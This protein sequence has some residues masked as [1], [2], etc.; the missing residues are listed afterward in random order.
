MRVYVVQYHD[1]YGH[2]D[3]RKVSSS[4]AGA[5]DYIIGAHPDA[6]VVQIEWNSARTY[7]TMRARYPGMRGGVEIFFYSIEEHQVID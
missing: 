7:C 2:R 6:S 1:A 3:V 5:E 4:K